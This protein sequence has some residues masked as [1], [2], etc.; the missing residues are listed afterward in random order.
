MIEWLSGPIDAVSWR[1]LAQIVLLSAGLTLACRWS[2]RH[3]SRSR[4]SLGVAAIWLLA[5][6]PLVL[7]IWQPRYQIGLVNPPAMPALT[8]IPVFLLVMWFG[9]A[10]AGA[11]ALAVQVLRTRRELQALPSLAAPQIHSMSAAF[12]ERLQMPAPAIVTGE[13]C[14]ASS[15][16]SAVLVVP[17]HFASWPLTAQRSVIAHELTHLQ[18]GDDRF[19]VALQL[20][21]RC[22]LF[23]PWLRLLYQRFV[24]ALEEACDERAAELV[25]VRA[26]YL[27][28]LAEAALRDGGNGYER[29]ELPAA[30]RSETQVAVATLI[31]A[32]HQHSF[33]QRLARLLGKQQFF[34][35]QSGALAAGMAVGLLVL[36][37]CTTFEFV[38]VPQRYLLSATTLP[39]SLQLPGAE[40]VDLQAGHEV[41]VVSRFPSAMPRRN[42][43]VT[44]AVIYP[45]RALIDGAEGEVLVAFSI[46]ADGS[47][48]Q[49]RVVRSTH[50]HY[51]NRAATRAVRQT[52]YAPRYNTNL[53]SDLSSDL[54]GISG[55]NT[56][57]DLTRAGELL[58]VRRGRASKP[59]RVQKLFLFRLHAA[60][61]G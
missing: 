56:A 22:Y 46:A 10:I 40:S 51:F 39:G 21:A 54:N 61:P 34:E 2:F 45:G 48:V 19:M 9:A 43:R 14:C 33:M 36:G 16:G 57:N 58:V 28:G 25:G 3:D 7:L 17:A 30:V 27:E 6:V 18:R 37:A 29:H 13:R 42:E 31:N 49:P 44:P 12:C 8:G 15:L 32:Q 55:V 20:I 23:C 53:S 24:H 50:P 52:V 1:W 60:D 59:N 35:V 41:E 4:R 26:L 5:W 47:T 11:V 38:N